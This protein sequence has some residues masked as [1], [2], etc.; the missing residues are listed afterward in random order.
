MY[1]EIETGLG[2]KKVDLQ[3]KNKNVQVEEI[4]LQN[5]RINQENKLQCQK[6]INL[7]K[8]YQRKNIIHESLPKTIESQTNSF[9]L[10]VKSLPEYDS[11]QLKDEA[12]CMSKL[13]DS[14]INN[15]IHDN[16]DDE[17][18]QKDSGTDE[19]FH[20]SHRDDLNR[21][22]NF[23]TAEKGHPSSEPD[24]L[25]AGKAS[26]VNDASDQPEDAQPYSKRKTLVQ[27]MMDV[28]LLTANA[29]QLRTLLE[30]GRNSETFYLCVVFIVF[31]LCIQ[32][33]VGVTM[34]LFRHKIEFASRSD[35][36][37]YLKRIDNFILVGVFLITVLNVFIATFTTI[38]HS[39][40]KGGAHTRK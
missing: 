22:P 13:V 27:G 4:E 11:S 40:S 8:E 19:N 29:N 33:I 26:D 14:N 39:L 16:N 32:I 10:H 23:D 21:S 28:A 17:K 1:P 3:I 9:G 34:I 30:Y 35:A 24:Q 6:E 2:H 20:L 7:Q 36:P 31:S 18:E 12:F 15:Q 5:P 38:G 25:N 37:L